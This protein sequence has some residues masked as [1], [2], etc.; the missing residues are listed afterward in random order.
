MRTFFKILGLILVVLIVI[1]L[2]NTFRFESRQLT[3]VPTAP[4]ISVSDSAI[5]RLSQAVQFRT[6]SNQDPTLLDTTQFEGFV[7]FLEKSFP[8]VHE[9]LWYTNACNGNG[10]IHSPCYLNGRAATLR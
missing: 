10:S 1:L 8:L 7:A 9:R 5:V 4:A 2:W 6:I 3:D